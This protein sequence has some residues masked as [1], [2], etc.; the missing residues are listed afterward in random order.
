[1]R[2]DEKLA[3]FIST[4]PRARDQALLREFEVE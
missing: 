4:N 2:P 3:A 1:V